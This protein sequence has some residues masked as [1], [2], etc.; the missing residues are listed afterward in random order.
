MPAAERSSR[1]DARPRASSV[2][3][4]RGSLPRYRSSLPYGWVLGDFAVRELLRHAPDAAL[5]V[6]WHGG[7]TPD[8][9]ARLEAACL[10]AGVP[11]RRDD[12]TVE[13][14]R[15]KGTAQVLGCFAKRASPLATDRDHLVLVAPADP[16]NLGTML[17]SA[18]AFGIEDVAVVGDADPWSP[19]VARASLGAL[20]ALRVAPFPSVAAY[21]AASPARDLWLLDGAADLTIDDVDPGPAPI[22][23]AAGPEWPGL[24]PDALRH[25]RTLRIAIDARVESLNVAVAVGIAL[26]RLRNGPRSEGAW[27]A[28]TPVEARS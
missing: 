13:A 5:D 3:P 14:K 20:F 27:G 21:R 26:H 15:S 11:C 23:L 8:R 9:G 22:A 28:A 2:E 12:R 18:L 16:G 1:S 24:G 17:R 4:P 7:L 6:R 25:G 10:E 19:H